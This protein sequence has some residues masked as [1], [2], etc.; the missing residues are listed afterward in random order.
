MGLLRQPSSARVRQQPWSSYRLLERLSRSV[1]RI[2]TRDTD[3]HRFPDI[4]P[5]DPLVRAPTE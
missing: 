3:F 5:I 4:E 1:R 2:Y